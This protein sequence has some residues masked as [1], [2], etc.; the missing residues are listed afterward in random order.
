VAS[1]LAI[2][3]A[4]SGAKTLFID[5]DMRSG[6]A[7]HLFGAQNTTGF[8]NILLQKIAWTDTV[9][10]TEFDHLFIIPCGPALHHTAEHLLGKVT[11]QFLIDIYDHFDYVIFDTPPVIILDDTLC[12]APKIDATLFVM[13]FNNS[14]TRSSRRALE[15]LD[16]R[17]A[18]VIGL[19]CN[20]VTLSETEYAYNY[21][22]RQYRGKYAEPKAPA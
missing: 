22:Y 9:F 19:V 12:L 10:M 21:N 15:L 3:L 20:G 6:K 4:F 5:G 2:T 18:N 13:R 11:D 8:S 7:S 16:Q 14:S 17:Q 1:N